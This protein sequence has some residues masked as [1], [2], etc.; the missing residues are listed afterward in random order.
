MQDHIFIS[1]SRADQN[2]VRKLYHDLVD[3]GVNCWLDVE[4]IPPGADWDAELEKAIK[5]SVAFIV[6]C[7]PTSMKSKNVQA[8]W[9]YAFELKKPLHPVVLKPCN[10]PFRLKIFQHVDFV[11]SGYQ[12]GVDLL[13][14]S[15]PRDINREE[16]K[17]PQLDP[18]KSNQVVALL[19]RSYENWKS[20]G[21]PMERAVFDVI[22]QSREKTTD[23]EPSILEFIFLSARKL[24]DA[25]RDESWQYWAS[26]IK[27]QASISDTIE[28]TILDSISEATLH[29]SQIELEVFASKRLLTKIAEII[30][31]S[32]DSDVVGL[33][34]DAC[35]RVCTKASFDQGE[36]EVLESALFDRYIGNPHASYAR[37]LGW[38]QSQKMFNTVRVNLKDKDSRDLNSIDKLDLIFL[39][40]M[41]NLEAI[42][43]LRSYT[44]PGFIFIP[45][46]WFLLGS[47]D[48]V[49][50][51]GAPSHEVFVPSFWIRQIPVTEVE[52]SQQKLLSV[53][54]ILTQ[55]PAH[56][57]SW[58]DARRWVNLVSE[59][60]NYPL[61]L[62]TEAMWEKAASWDVDNHVKRKYPWGDNTKKEYCNTVESNRK[63]FTPVGAFI[64][65][66]NS[67]YG[68]SDM[69]GNV[70]EWTTSIFKP[71][72]YQARTER[73][74]LEHKADRTTSVF[75][76][77]P[78]QIYAKGDNLKYQADRVM[79][80]PSHD[81]RRGLK[82]G[83]TT[84]I[85]FGEN[86]SFDNAGMRVAI[87]VD[88]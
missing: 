70:W 38:M 60:T 83:C 66:G 8:E 80:G 1:Y 23:V 12:R 13:I 21:L 14:E 88:I 75:G 81:A 53:E 5:D 56:N 16:R 45:A 43:L 76:S 9:H 78:N 86:Y 68:V 62:P 48:G 82:H 85:A 40:N 50:Y 11:E 65:Q 7:T 4:H 57:I 26:R 44:P 29:R 46:G 6:I 63:A 58:A 74:N 71:Y 10:L 61:S 25:A 24:K 20:F 28:N 39:A 51:F 2:E 54:E 15:L 31:I 19:E 22:D 59:A 42:D 87:V 3:R 30:A 67:L 73:D 84:R 36:F 37:I 69:V 18:D 34:T 64:P 27:S 55:L 33:L 47:D 79:R 35:I 41:V 32:P 72:P 52:F 49:E 77:Y 17:I